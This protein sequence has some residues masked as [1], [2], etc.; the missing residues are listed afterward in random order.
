MSDAVRDAVDAWAASGRE[1]A[2]P[3][4]VYEVVHTGF[5]LAALPQV[6]DHELVTALCS[7]APVERV[8]SVGWSLS[9]G[10]GSHIGGTRDGVR[11]VFEPEDVANRE[12]GTVYVSAVRPAL[13]PGYLTIVGPG[14]EPG[15]ALLRCYLAA[16]AASSVTVVRTVAAALAQRGLRFVLKAAD[17]PEGYQRRDAIVLYTSM[18]EGSAAVTAVVSG[19][20]E[21]SLSER[22]P[23]LAERMAPGVATAES[24]EDGVS[25]GLHRCTVLAS[26]LRK[27]GRSGSPA[28]VTTVRDQFAAA[29]IDPDA[30]WRALRPDGKGRD[31]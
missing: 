2:T 15:R 8:P 10:T 30:P 20:P 6:P 29:G 17:T 16:R 4:A 13:H 24:P 22:T 18:A 5:G 3:Q 14:G 11:V 25:F 7:A 9:G 28:V 21:N 31:G 23:L 27:A 19:L 12:Q 1:N 26:A